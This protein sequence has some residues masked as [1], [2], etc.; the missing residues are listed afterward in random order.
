MVNVTLTTSNLDRGLTA[1]PALLFTNIRPRHTRILHV[2]D[3]QSYQKITGFGAAMT[4]S[5]A[6]LIHDQL[7]APQGDSVMAAL[8]GAKGIRL[9]FL[10]VPIGASDYTVNGQPYTYDDMPLGQTDPTLQKF[11]IGHDLPYI[12]PSI[13]QALALN[14]A[15]SIIATPW[16]AP[17]WM[18]TNEDYG[19]WYPPSKAVPYDPYGDLISG[20]YAPYARYFVKFLQA[21]AAQG[22]P[23]AAITAFNEPGSLAPFPG[24][25]VSTA[26]ATNF[27]ANYLHPALAA[28]GFNPAVFGYDWGG[29]LADAEGYLQSQAAPYLSG[30]SWHCYFGQPAM[31]QLHDA[32]PNVEQIISECS[33]GIIPYAASEMGISGLRN[34]ASA[35][36]MWNLALDPSKGPV[37]PPNYGCNGCTGLVTVDTA[38]RS[39]TYSLNYFQLGQFSKFIDQG[40]VRISSDRWVSDFVSPSP[41]ASLPTRPYGVTPGLDNVAVENPNGQKVLIAYNNS[42]RPVR[43]AVEWHRMFFVAR[44]A[45]SDTATF[46]W[47]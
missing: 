26:E 8:F 14:P 34:W 24:M 21:Y 47:H 28:A 19:A 36:A 43:F 4:D 40:A 1:M 46:V 37:E 39:V 42:T 13:R 35:V 9:N 22:I 16:T 23:V 12:I 41:Y 32:Y 31:S 2:S 38:D 5:S 18:K 7:P 33:P 6:W 15:T 45:P 44:L 27:I 20:D 30:I 10:R 29:G 3:Q 25:Y 17:P 11:S